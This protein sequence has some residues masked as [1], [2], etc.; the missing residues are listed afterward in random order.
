MKK[1]KIR[2]TTLHIRKIPIDLKAY[3]KAWCAKRGKSM[4]DIIVDH[5]NND[6]SEK[7]K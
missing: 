7:T 4:R 6:V 5:M 1:R 3:F 2:E